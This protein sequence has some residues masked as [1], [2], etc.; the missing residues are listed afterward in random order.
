MHLVGG[1]KSGIIY[2]I[3]KIQN[4]KKYKLCELGYIYFIHYRAER[5]E[6]L[7]EFL[8]L[9]ESKQHISVHK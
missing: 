1:G 9:F 2:N 7:N 3:V 5:N 4:S 8:C 6:R